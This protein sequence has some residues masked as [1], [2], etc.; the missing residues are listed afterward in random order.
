MKKKVKLITTI[1][2]LGLALA[3]MAFGVYAALTE[4]FTVTSSV[5]FTASK[6]I[7]VD[8]SVATTA[9]GAELA[10]EDGAMIK[11]YTEGANGK[12]AANAGATHANTLALKTATYKAIG[13]KVTY[14][15][16]VVNYAEFAIVVTVDLPEALVKNAK[17]LTSVTG[18]ASFEV[19]AS[20]G[21]GVS[22]THTVVIELLR[23]DVS[24]SAT[25]GAVEIGYS[26]TAK[27]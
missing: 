14:T 20:T 1:A 5:N 4:T 15:C 17:T 19:G 3:L 26:I 13:D 25:E 11:T 23:S 24:F 10:G 2:S 16:T 7:L 22:Q 8:F 6:D 18:D 9:T 12:V 21:E 27:A